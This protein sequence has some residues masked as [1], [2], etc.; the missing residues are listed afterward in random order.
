MLSNGQNS[1]R[2]PVASFLTERL[3]SNDFE[4]LNDALA[5]LFA[6]LRKVSQRYKK[7]DFSDRG[8]TL[9]ALGAVSRFLMQFRAAL[10]RVDGIE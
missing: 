3:S 10:G 2:G 1:G 9:I 6:D 7:K 8:A 5:T 4:Q